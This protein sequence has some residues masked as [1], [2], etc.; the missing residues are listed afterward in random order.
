MENIKDNLTGIYNE[1]YLKYHYQEYISKY[2][3]AQFVMIDFEKFKNINDVYGHNIGDQYLIVF[4]SIINNVFKDSLVVRLHGDEFAILT[5]Y[6]PEEIQQRFLLCDKMIQLSVI[7]RKIPATFGFNAGSTRAEH[8]IQNTKEKADYMMYYAKKNKKKYQEF[9]EKIWKTKKDEDLFLHKIDTYLKK[10]SFQYTMRKI[11]HSD[12]NE[13]NMYQIYTKGIDG[14]SILNELNY[15]IL[16]KNQRLG[17]LDI[18]N[19]QY[20]LEHV[21]I[22]KRQI[23]INVDYLTI[24]SLEQL[25]DYLKVLSSLRKIDFHS[26]I[27]SIN[28]NKIISE[29]YFEL[30]RKIEILKDLGFQIRLDQYSSKIGDEIWESTIV[31]Y[32]KFDHSYWNKGMDCKKIDYCLRRKV[33]MLMDCDNPII[34]MF[35]FI[36]KE[37]QHQYIDS[38]QNNDI[39]VSG[40]YYSKEKKLELK[41]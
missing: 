9:D 18:H 3:D 28:L 8:G 30:I 5:K 4:A 27:L 26:I 34:P 24:L 7:E 41:R 16:K 2:V 17:I 32:I 21:D 38:F 29:Q 23:I 19:I 33:D 15:E 37:E 6:H 12:K 31:D 20:L 35:D 40:N 13:T 25:Y 10:D 22:L 39:L 1:F 36:E 11:F 14:S